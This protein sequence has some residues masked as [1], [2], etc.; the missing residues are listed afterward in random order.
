MK[1]TMKLFEIGMKQVLKDG[2]LIALIPA[3][4]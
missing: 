4:F 1:H 3:P 2:M